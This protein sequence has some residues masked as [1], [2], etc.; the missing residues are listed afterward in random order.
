MNFSSSKVPMSSQSFLSPM[1]TGL[2]QD[3][4]AQSM[5]GLTPGSLAAMLLLAVMWGLSIPV[6]KLGLQTL[7][8]LTLTAFRFAVAVPL[9]LVFAVGRHALPWR[10]VPRVAAL[11]VLGIGGGRL[12][13]PSASPVRRRPSA[14]SFPPPFRYSS[15]SSQP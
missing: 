15:F 9:L 3:A 14:R 8:P 13:R 7:P 2:G 11:G 10:A 5:A 6:T 4:S 12:P 1:G